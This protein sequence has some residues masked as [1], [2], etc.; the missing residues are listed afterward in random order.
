MRRTPVPESI[1][2]ILEALAEGVEGRIT[3]SHALTQGVVIVDTLCAGHDLLTAHEE[4]V[5]VREVRGGGIGVGVEG[6]DGE[7][8]FVHG[9]E[10][11]GVFLRDEGAE[12]AF[13]RGTGE[14]E[15]G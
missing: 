12:G 6:P 10:V 9:E 15:E 14:G 2:V 3:S 7:G 1:R 5:A 8:V 4:V 11:A 13:L